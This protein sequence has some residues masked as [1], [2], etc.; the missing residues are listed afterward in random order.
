MTQA[1]DNVISKAT[2]LKRSVDSFRLLFNAFEPGYIEMIDD[3]SRSA[4]GK[5]TRRND[6]EIFELDIQKGFCTIHHAHELAY[7][8]HLIIKGEV[9]IK[10]DGIDNILRAGQSLIT[11]K[12]LLHTFVALEDTKIV[13]IAV[14][15]LY[16]ANGN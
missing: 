11:S 8:L 9:N 14:P 13:T 10:Q 6:Y 7:E 16:E 4:I 2:N 1:I 5:M 15:T 3:N 12:G